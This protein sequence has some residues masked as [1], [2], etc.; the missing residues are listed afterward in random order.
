MKHHLTFIPIFLILLVF[1]T[2]DSRSQ[3]QPAKKDFASSLS[4]GPYTGTAK[5]TLHLHG[6]K[7][8]PS[9]TGTGSF[10]LSSKKAN[11]S[12]IALVCKLK[13]GDGFSFAIPGT[14]NGMAWRA[15]A[16]AGSFA[17]AQNGTM[18]GKYTSPTQEISWNGT[19]FDDR[20]MLNLKITYLKDQDKITK[21]SIIATQLDLYRSVTKST[22]TQNSK[23]KKGC[24]TIVWETRSVFNLYSGGVDIIRVPVCHD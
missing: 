20:I 16:K 10:S 9:V 1:C 8:L 24:K 6:H 14:Q 12:T 22:K 4:I 17:I 21:G 11:S 7:S 15:S 5:S 2:S 13:S 3:Q 23:N 19:L 18:S